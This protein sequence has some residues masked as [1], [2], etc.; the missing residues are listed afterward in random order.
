MMGFSVSLLD[1]STLTFWTAALQVAIFGG[2]LLIPLILWRRRAAARHTVAML[3]LLLALAS[4]LGAACSLSW[5]LGWTPRPDWLRLD[6]GPNERLASPREQTRP[7]PTQVH[8]RSLLTESS[9][10]P[11]SMERIE[12]PDQSA[13][14]PLDRLDAPTSQPTA[15]VANQALEPLTEPPD[16]VTRSV[17]TPHG[18]A[19]T[20]R[21]TQRPV[22]VRP[23]TAANATSQSTSTTAWMALRL[24]FVAW[25]LGVLAKGILG[26]RTR[27]RLSRLIQKAQPVTD[28][29]ASEALRSIA[30]TQGLEVPPRLLTSET[31]ACPFVIGIRMPT[32]V[33]PTSMLAP[34]SEDMLRHVLAHECAHVARR[35]LLLG[36]LH[37]WV[38]LLWWPHPIVRVHGRILSHA[39]EELCDRRVLRHVAP[40][41]YARTLLTLGEGL[42]GLQ[43][44]PGLSMFSRRHPLTKRIA[45][46]LDPRLARAESLGK[47]RGSVLAVFAFVVASLALG[48]GPPERSK[49]NEVLAE[50]DPDPVPVPSERKQ[51]EVEAEAV[52]EA[53]PLVHALK[54]RASNWIEPP[55]Q[56]K[57]LKY[58]L[59]LGHEVNSIQATRARPTRSEAWMGTTLHGGFQKLIHSTE[60]FAI[61]LSQLKESNK[62]RISAKWKDPAGSFGVIAGNGVEN[63]WLG[64]FSHSARSTQILVDTERLVP[65]EE[66]TG[67]TTIRYSRWRE[68]APERWVPLQIDVQSN[69]THYRMHFSWLSEAAWLLSRSESITPKETRLMTRTANVQVND[70]AIIEAEQETARQTRAAA[71]E[72][73]AMLDHN[74]PW[75]D[76][77]KTGAGW[78]PSYQTLSYRF[79]HLREDVWVDCALDTGGRAALEVSGDGQ[80]KMGDRLGNRQITLD[81]Q[82]WA[83]AKRGEAFA[84][85][86]GRAKD[87]REQPFDLA[88]KQYARMGCQLDL[89]LFRY[90][91]RLDTASIAMEDGVWNGQACRVATVSNMGPDLALGCG[92]MLAFSSWS[93]MHHIRPSREVIFIDPVR[94]VPLHETLTSASNGAF[95]IDFGDYVELTPGEWAPRS[96]RVENRGHFTC[97]YRFQVVAGTHWMLDEVVSWFDPKDKSRGVVQ[98]VEVNGQAGLLKEALNQVKAA[99]TLFDGDGEPRGRVALN[100]TPFALGHLMD[101]GPYAVRVTTPDPRQVA[102]DVSTRDPNASGTIPLGFLNEQGQLLFAPSISL[103][104]KAEGLRRG[105]LTL[106]ASRPWRAVRSLV[107]PGDKTL[108]E[109]PA[110]EVDVVPFQWDRSMVVN[111]PDCLEPN[112][113]STSFRERPRNGLTRAY[114]ARVDRTK[115]GESRLTLDLVSIDGTHAFELDLTAALL[116]AGGELLATGQHS[117][118]LRVDSEP[119]QKA[120]T[121]PL[122]PVPPEVEPRW[123]LIGV[124]PGAVVAAPMGTVWASFAVDPPFDAA[125]LL[126]APDPSCRQAGLAMLDE[127][128]MRRAIYS[129][130]LGDRTASVRRASKATPTRRTQ[131]EPHAKALTQILDTP[132][133]AH[134]K[135]QAIRFLAYSEAE[136]ALRA[137]KRWPTTLH[138]SSGTQPPSA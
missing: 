71:Q 17:S 35:D 99:R 61:Q 25:M 27:R 130:F 42:S 131:L 94:K 78:R 80:G 65:L 13:P 95:E 110:V 12:G 107:V 106:Q 98:A 38:E 64:Y 40:T 18:P 69:T 48:I 117:S 115:E 100:T 37:H 49:A 30:A 14:Y 122:G 136:G 58:N 129:E 41:E 24:G 77:G 70:G 22:M 137:S 54:A 3:T 2:G 7:R 79:H 44:A 66:Q 36:R 5:G 62:V 89:P 67:T 32:I 82:E 11:P 31:V 76:P 104:P 121:I 111:I 19:P 60:S 113:P 103:E 20:T 21:E 128:R 120:F 84:S 133:S 39:R 123:L 85:I 53:I 126:A 34:G 127:A 91:E 16:Q 93:Y 1:R 138:R 45:D 119:I 56:L 52:I 88:L 81:N 116:G 105:S 90:H 8:E 10:L 43:T 96:I 55:P 135:A 59:V 114:H 83:S 57:H 101:V 46:L 118:E 102:I 109:Q 26:L 87:Q 6:L 73:R 134:T 33:I 86:K 15:T 72:V 4:P 50:Q 74:R 97:E 112:Q 29:P 63:R 51:V 23:E 68:V 125:T 9:A 124:S 132:N 92:T 47:V 75:L 28:H 108:K